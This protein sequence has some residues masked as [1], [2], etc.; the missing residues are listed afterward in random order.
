MLSLQAEMNENVRKELFRKLKKENCFWSYDM[1][2]MK[3]I[4]D[5]LLIEYV[6]L[7]LDI[8]DINLLFK[9]FPYKKVKK[10]WIENVVAQGEM[11]YVLN[12][13]FAW[14]YFHAKK[15]GAYV[16]AMATRQMNKRFVA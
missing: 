3:T 2:K 13:F 7:Y 5:E 4:S 6:F 12:K 10:A 8:D 14:Y 1:S 11:Y 15:P 16:K 9:I